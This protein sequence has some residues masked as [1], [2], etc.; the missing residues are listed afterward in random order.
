MTGQER[1]PGTLRSREQVEDIMRRVGMADR[2]PEARE[3]LPEEVDL[4]R[5]AGLL[6]KLGLS[7]DRIVNDMGGGPW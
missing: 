2:I 7:I 3:I 5:D 6:L 4:D 1:G